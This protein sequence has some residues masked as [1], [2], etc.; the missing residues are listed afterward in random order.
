VAWGFVR[1]RV[2]APLAQMRT[3]I[4]AQRALRYNFEKE[5][6]QLEKTQ[7]RWDAAVQSTLGTDKESGALAQHAFRDD[8]A[9]LLQQHG[10]T[11]GLSTTPGTPRVDRNR[12]GFRQGF[13]ELPVKVSVKGSLDNLVAF[14]K[15]LYQRPYLA[16]VSNLSLV[17]IEERGSST[18][19]KDAAA[20]KTPARRGAS[21]RTPAPATH[22]PGGWRLGIDMTVV[23]LVLPTM[24]DSKAAPLT[25]EQ[26][27][28]GDPSRLGNAD[29]GPIGSLNIFRK[30][31]PPPPQPP[32]EAPETPPV[33]VRPDTPR[34]DRPPPREDPPQP[35]L[36]LVAST[37][38]GPDQIAYLRDDRRK[39]EPPTELRL[40]DVLE[41]ARVVLIHPRGIVMRVGEG[42][43][44]KDYWI[45]LGAKLSARVELDPASEPDVAAELQL[46]LRPE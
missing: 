24:A 29:Y 31:Q 45:A 20:S 22:S 28:R 38:I 4:D 23:A 11:D 35:G 5:L 2:I 26:L 27:S 36:T 18:A 34:P 32:V 40:N 14:L 39:G 6:R 7:T 41:D 8:L 17:G 42:D 15:D 37:G 46:A 44:A 25:R 1:A 10:L 3:D 9:A 12:K 21:G 16:R 43:G 13:V 33:A 19:A 30:Y